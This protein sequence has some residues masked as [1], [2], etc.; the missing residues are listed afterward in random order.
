MSLMQDRFYSHEIALEE[1]VTAYVHCTWV[2]NEP[3]H[4][5]SEVSVVVREG[6]REEEIGRIKGPIQRESAN[7]QGTKIAEDWYAKQK[8]GATE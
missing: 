3:G 8:V 4:V 6:G 5:A 1:G 2:D 7:E